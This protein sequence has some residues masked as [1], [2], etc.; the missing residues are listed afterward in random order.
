M[1]HKVHPKAFR[2]NTVYT[3]DSKWFARGGQ[4]VS[5]LQEDV[6]LRDYLRKSLKESGLNDVSI[7]RT[8]KQMT[9]T[10]HAAKPGVVIGRSGAGIEDLKKKIMK[11]FFPGRR[12]ALNINVTEVSRPSLSSEIVG[13]QI[14][15]DIVRRL[16]FRRSMK[17]AIER[18]MKAGAKGVKLT[19]SGRLN[20]AEI[21][22][23]ETLA[24][25]SIP[26]HNLRADIDFARVR[27]NTVYGVIG[28]KIWIYRGD[29]FEKDAA[30]ETQSAEAAPEAPRRAPRARAPR[31]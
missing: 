29:V 5:Q 17:M 24:Q 15:Q 9:I 31:A 27:A 20:G 4:F 3:W 22:R 13:E 2:L 26:L 8:P 10:I 19:L 21:A 28:I 16:P 25:G 23:T 7:E 1:G 14:A 12:L 6:E 11:M 30:K 18:V